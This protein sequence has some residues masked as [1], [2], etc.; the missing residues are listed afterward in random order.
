MNQDEAFDAFY[1]GLEKKIGYRLSSYLR[2][3]LDDEKKIKKI[4]VNVGRY[5]G[6]GKIPETYILEQFKPLFKP[7][8]YQEIVAAQIKQ[9][10]DGR[11][12]SLEALDLAR[13]ARG[14]SGKGKVKGDSKYSK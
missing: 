3:T 8:D 5:R 12:K 7:A 11:K 2:E 14:S 1:I 9:K 10:E 6:L 13:G 4:S